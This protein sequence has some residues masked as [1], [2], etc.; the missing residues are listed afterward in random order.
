M[1]ARL[2]TSRNGWLTE[3]LKCGEHAAIL[4]S[5][6]QGLEDT[7]AC[8]EALSLSRWDLVGFRTGVHL[9]PN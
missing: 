9:N 8:S 3:L 6:D 4:R 1:V 2:A 5:T 7:E